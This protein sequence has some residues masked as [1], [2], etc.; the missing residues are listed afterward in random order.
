MLSDNSFRTLIGT[1]GCSAI[2]LWLLPFVPSAH[3]SEDLATLLTWDGIDGVIAQSE[4]LYW[5]SLVGWL[6][7][8]LLLWF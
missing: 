4:L 6:L 5:T 8:V 7:S 1:F 2:V 3:Y